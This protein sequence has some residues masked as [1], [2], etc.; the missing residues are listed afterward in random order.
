MIKFT[1]KSKTVVT[2]FVFLILVFFFPANSFAQSSQILSVTP[3]LF[4]ISVEPGDLWQSMVKV[5]NSNPYPITV[6]AEVVNFS[7]KGEEGQ[8]KFVPI[9]NGGQEGTTLAEWI[10]VIGGPYIIPAEQSKEVPFIV[11]VPDNAAPGGHFAAILIGTQP[12][13]SDD[14]VL[15]Q[16]SQ[17]VTSL[18]FVRIAGDIVEKANIRQFS[19]ENW[20]VETPSSEFILRFENKGNVHIQ[21]RGDI[22]IYNMWGKERG[23][24]PINKQTHFGNVLPESVRE[25]YFRWEGERSFTDIGRYSAEVVLSYGEDGHKTVDAKTFF[26]VVPVK[27][28]LIT[29]G[30]VIGFILFVTWAIKL[31]VR[32]MLTLAGVEVEQLIEGEDFQ[33]KEIKSKTVKVLNKKS[34]F[35][36]L[37][38]GFND[39]IERI[40]KINAVF[41]VVVTFT[42][43]IW[44]YKLFFLVIA[45]LSASFVGIVFYIGDVS[46]N[47]KSYEVTLVGEDGDTVI[48][49]EEILKEEL[50]NSLEENIFVNEE[51]HFILELINA[52]GVPGI[53]AESAVVLEDFGYNIDLISSNL[54]EVIEETKLIFDVGLLDEAEA[55][56][57]IFGDVIFEEIAEEDFEAEEKLRIRI[58]VG[59]DKSNK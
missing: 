9:F 59:V 26:W 13:D 16:T 54:E 32:R 5:V 38:V 3:P 57:V 10:D 18:F 6:Y 17:V 31:Y 28:G 22:T 25:F 33:K 43:F 19:V 37:H 42:G 7:P 11:Q 29:F 45:I 14:E 44:S 12:L 21:P 35:Q 39:F 15:V 50:E 1:Y 4:Q 36:P 46:Q 41:D 58:I 24:I 49:S 48:T 55:L 2:A 34:V 23:V 51:Q 40:K 53:A 20:F 27:S 8:G 30:I 56:G 47:E 52:S